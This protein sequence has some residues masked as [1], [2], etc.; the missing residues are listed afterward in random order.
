MPLMSVHLLLVPLGPHACPWAPSC[1]AWPPPLQAVALFG[2][3]ALEAAG[4]EQT[5][6]VWHSEYASMHSAT[7]LKEAPR[8]WGTHVGTMRAWSPRGIPVVASPLC[9]V[10]GVC[11]VACVGWCV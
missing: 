6:S 9:N 3:G 11:S 5:L 10:H 1:P 4:V 2:A 7:E 8:T